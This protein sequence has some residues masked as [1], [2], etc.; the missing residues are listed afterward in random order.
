MIERMKIIL[1]KQNSF[2][3]EA[4]VNNNRIKKINFYIT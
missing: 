1:A 4:K 3:N 2:S